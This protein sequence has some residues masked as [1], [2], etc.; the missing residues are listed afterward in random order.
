[1]NSKPTVEAPQLNADGTK[2]HSKS[3]NG[4][5]KDSRRELVEQTGDYKL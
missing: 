4:I 1:M 5:T 3:Y 2:V